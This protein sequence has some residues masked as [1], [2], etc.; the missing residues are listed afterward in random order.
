MN[1]TAPAYPCL[2]RAGVG[3]GNLDARRVGLISME[4]QVRG[5]FQGAQLYV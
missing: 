3:W 5:S 4:Y 1:R 2:H